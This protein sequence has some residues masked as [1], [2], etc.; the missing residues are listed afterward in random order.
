MKFEKYITEGIQ[1]KGIFKAMFMAG[2]PGS[3]KTYTATKIRSGSIEAK[4]VNTDKLFPFFKEF[5]G[6]IEGWT[7]IKDRVKNINKDQLALYIN[8]ILPLAVDGTAGRS[9][10]GSQGR[11]CASL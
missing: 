4:I 11:R 1:D 10:R 8:S 7:K 2:H 9:H 6:T 3:G 5:W